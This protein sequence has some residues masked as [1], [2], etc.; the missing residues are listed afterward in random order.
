MSVGLWAIEVGAKKKGRLNWSATPSKE[1]RGKVV[2]N[3]PYR[4]DRALRDDD[5]RSR[6]L[7]TYLMAY[8]IRLA[9][10]ETDVGVRRA[11]GLDRRAPRERYRAFGRLRRATRFLYRAPRVY[12]GALRVH[13]VGAMSAL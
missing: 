8:G 10:L 12:G 11:S 4:N 9:G 7:C 2:L 3:G 5:R 1:Y 13:R 6:L